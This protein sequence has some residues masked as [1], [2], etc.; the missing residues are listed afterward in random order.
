MT[1]SEGLY[2]ATP[3]LSQGM[4]PALYSP[5][6]FPTLFLHPLQYYFVLTTIYTFAGIKNSANNRNTIVFTSTRIKKTPE[7]FLN[8]GKFRLSSV[9]R[10]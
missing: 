1:L 7:S 6:V 5:I 9:F 2:V 8:A 3:H 10:N 4:T